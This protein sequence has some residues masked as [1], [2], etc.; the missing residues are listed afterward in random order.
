MAMQLEE[1]EVILRS[2]L[3]NQNHLSPAPSLMFDL[4]LKMVRVS[5]ETQIGAQINAQGDSVRR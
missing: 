1:T 3:P 5:L 2:G 4:Y